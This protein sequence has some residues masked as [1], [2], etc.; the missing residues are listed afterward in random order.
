MVNIW[1]GFSKKRLCQLHPY[2]S[3]IAALAFNH[4]GTLLAIASSYTFEQGEKEY[5]KR[6]RLSSLHN[7]VA[8]PSHAPDTTVIRAVSEAEAKPK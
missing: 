7:A 4:S 1:D 2:P 3:S 8:H 5:E 6:A